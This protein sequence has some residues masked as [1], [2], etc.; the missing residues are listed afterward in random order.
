MRTNETPQSFSMG[1]FYAP[2][3]G[4]SEGGILVCAVRPSVCLSVRP[5]SIRLYGSRETQESLMLE[6]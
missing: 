4:E 3:F 5:P 2:N 1:H 6:P